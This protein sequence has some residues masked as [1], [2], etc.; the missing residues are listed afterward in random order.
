MGKTIQAKESL[1]GKYES[2][3]TCAKDQTKESADMH[4]KLA[5]CSY[6]DDLT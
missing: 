4:L 6:S 2:G 3:D 5:P 1:E